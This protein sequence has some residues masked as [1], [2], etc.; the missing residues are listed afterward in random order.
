MDYGNGDMITYHTIRNDSLDKKNVRQ[1]RKLNTM[2]FSL[3][4]VE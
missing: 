1:L 2:K 3:S 4:T